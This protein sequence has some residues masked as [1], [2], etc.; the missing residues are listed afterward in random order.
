MLKM[1]E[2]LWKNSLIIAKDVWIIHINF[3]SIAVTFSE[4]KLGELLLYHPS[5]YS[6][7]HCMPCN[8]Y[9][10]KHFLIWLAQVQQVVS[11]ILHCIQTCHS[12][13]IMNI[14]YWK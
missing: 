5:Y 11:L 1:M 7:L 14:L 12:A 2:T 13:T 9:I 3:I 4:E 6:W 8:M 10:L